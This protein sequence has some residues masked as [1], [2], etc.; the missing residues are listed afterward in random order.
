VGAVGYAFDLNGGAKSDE[1]GKENDGLHDWQL[2]PYIGI[3][4]NSTDV[5]KKGTTYT[6]NTRDAGV[7]LFYAWTPS[8]S[9]PFGPSTSYVLTLRPDY[10]WNE[11]NGSH[12]AS[13]NA[14]FVPSRARLLNARLS[15][16]ES[17]VSINSIFDLRL[18]DGHYTGFGTAKPG[19]LSNY[20][21]FGSRFGFDIAT[22]GKP[23]FPLDWL[24]TETLLYGFHGTPRD[25]HYF[26][27][28]F[29]LGLDSKKDFT[30]DLSYSTGRREDTGEPERGW[31]LSFGAK[32]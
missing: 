8:Q 23:D 12:I 22:R 26:K 30:L 24:I 11:V 9:P 21:R 10:L 15:P 18:D 3:N 29:S 5:A 28:T 1:D 4:D 14:S 16:D 7:T 17:P 20:L 32:Y 13:L 27:S 2:V 25:I 31:S 6:A 19:T